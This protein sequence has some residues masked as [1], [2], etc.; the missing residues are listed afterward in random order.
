MGIFAAFI[1]A[2]SFGTSQAHAMISGDLQVG[3]RGSQVTELQQFL[4]TNSDIYPAGIVSGYYGT[5]TQAAVVQFQVA[6]GISQV[7]RVGPITRSKIN[8]IMAS[9]LGLDTHAPTMSNISVQTT[10]TGATLNWTTN[11][12]ARGQ[13]FYDT[14]PI[15]SNEETRQGQLAYIGGTL[16]NNAG[17]SASQTVSV[18]GLHPNTL[19]YYIARAIDGSQNYSV[20]LMNSFRTGNQ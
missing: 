1:V 3:S 9:G 19:Y 14:S 7:G 11:E 20:S 16:S 17:L 5:L 10:N 15:Q 18:S 2:A 12:G 13:V 6:Y 8:E 4:A